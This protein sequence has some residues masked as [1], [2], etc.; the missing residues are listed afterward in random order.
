MFLVLMKTWI[1]VVSPHMTQQTPTSFTFETMLKK[2]YNT[3]DFR[4]IFRWIWIFVE[5]ISTLPTINVSNYSYSRSN[6]WRR[7]VEVLES[8]LIARSN[9]S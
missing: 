7:S 2:L 3:A 6:N 8:H 4:W 9:Y 1:S 5:V